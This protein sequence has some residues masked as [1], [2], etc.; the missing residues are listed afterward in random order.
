MKTKVYRS[1]AAFARLGGSCCHGTT[2]QFFLLAAFCRWSGYRFNDTPGTIL[3]R[4]I[5]NT[6]I[7]H[8]YSFQL[9][10]AC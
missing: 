9:L 2:E 10:N 6:C 7:T 3:D 5:G 8:L 4:E 1:L